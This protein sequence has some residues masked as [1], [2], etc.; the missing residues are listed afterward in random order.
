MKDRR[1]RPVDGME[2]H[3]GNEAICYRS[4]LFNDDEDIR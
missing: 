1:A 3:H 4:L 2:I